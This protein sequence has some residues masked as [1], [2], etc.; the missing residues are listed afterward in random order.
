MNLKIFWKTF[1]NIQ[2]KL[3]VSPWTG[4]CFWFL[5]NMIFSKKNQF[6]FLK[7]QTKEQ[8]ATDPTIRGRKKKLASQIEKGTF[9]KLS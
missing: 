1:E 4:Y 5:Q 3:V 2:R 9:E 8:L 7:K 6:L